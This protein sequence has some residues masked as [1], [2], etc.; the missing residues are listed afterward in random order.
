MEGGK[1]FLHDGRG[2]KARSNVGQGKVKDPE[3]HM[4]VINARPLIRESS[5]DCKSI[6]FK[7]S[8]L[9][10]F[11]RDSLFFTILLIINTIVM[12]GM[13]PCTIRNPS[14]LERITSCME[15]NCV[16]RFFV[17]NYL[18]K[19]VKLSHFNSCQRLLALQLKNLYVEVTE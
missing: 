16:G 19:S 10:I 1:H 15:N 14:W 7:Y 11:Y 18:L 2:S 8:I 6:F 17:T 9:V 12:Q 5:I 13:L 4:N 3:K